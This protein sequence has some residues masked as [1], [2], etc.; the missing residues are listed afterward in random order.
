MWWRKRRDASNSTVAESDEAKRGVP[1]RI[2]SSVKRAGARVAQ[3]CRNVIGKI[4]DWWQTRFRDKELIP[5][6]WDGLDFLPSARKVLK[7]KASPIHRVVAVVVTAF[8]IG[9]SKLQVLW[10]EQSHRQELARAEREGIE[11]L[12]AALEVLE[13][14]PS[15]L[16]RM[17]SISIMAFATIAAA[18]MFFSHIDVVVT[19]QGRVI[20]SGRV[21]VIQ[22]AEA[23]IVRSIE[24]R[25]GQQV[26][27]GE[28]LIEL[29]ATTTTADRER[30]ARELLETKIDA[31]R[32]RAQ[33]QGD[34][35]SFEL[36]EG[37][38]EQV[39]ST[40]RELLL[41]RLKE[42]AE[43]LIAFESDIAGRQAERN[44]IQAAI[45]K[46][47]KALPLLKRRLRKKQ[48]LKKRGFVS[49]VEIIES[50]LEVINHEKEL[51]VQRYRLVEADATLRVAMSQR[52]QREAEFRSQMLADLSDAESRRNVLA[53]ELIKAEQRRSLQQLRSPVDG[54]VQQLAVNTI[55]GVVTAAQT[56]MVVVPADIRLEVEA[57]VLNKDIG[58]IE[59]GQLAAVKFETYS[60]T[61]HGYIDGTLEW[62][63]NDVVADPELGA[64]YPVRI[65]LADLQMPNEIN[66]RRGIVAPGMSVTADI[67][68]GKRRVLDYFLAPILRYKEES[69][70]ER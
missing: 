47:E 1:A 13:K 44:A 52:K 34:A 9:T 60:F 62:V 40:Q 46:L 28:L 17:I 25:D 10:R 31:A 49:D 43:Q 32:L 69:L 59:A 23:G 24:V 29:D 48:S 12:P 37:V 30:L 42:Q 15:P 2:W 45:E 56:L 21:K 64:V 18:W 39:A 65:S 8:A 7:K 19:A 53:Q 57:Q 33:L 27:K 22:P 41:S 36:P 26:R 50:K 54:T 5:A 58:F 16:G 67:A 66:G 3:A 4:R 61:R 14:P 63:G 68:I 35:E 51:N 70:R 11:F 20:P 6:S 38:N 55:G